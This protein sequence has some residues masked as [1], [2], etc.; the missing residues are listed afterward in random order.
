MNKNDKIN[1][2]KHFFKQVPVLFSSR[3]LYFKSLFWKINDMKLNMTQAQWTAIG[4][5]TSPDP[6]FTKPV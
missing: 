3:T 4:I 1:N 5:L 6:E 2:E